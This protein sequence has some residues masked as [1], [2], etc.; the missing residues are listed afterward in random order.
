[1]LWFVIR[2]KWHKKCVCEATK[3]A[4]QESKNKVRAFIVRSRLS[5]MKM[6]TKVVNF[7]LIKLHPHVYFE[8]RK[9]RRF[10]QEKNHLTPIY[11]TIKLLFS[12]TPIR[13]FFLLMHCCFNLVSMWMLVSYAKHFDCV[14]LTFSRRDISVWWW[15]SIHI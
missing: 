3:Q 13:F 5:K 2:V 4:T 8:S 14:D 9:K 12:S 1:M 15:R 11:V 7:F 10:K 6:H